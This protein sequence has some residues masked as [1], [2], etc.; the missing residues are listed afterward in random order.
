VDGHFR[1]KSPYPPPLGTQPYS[2][3]RL[4]SGN[5]IVPV[6]S[7]RAE[8]VGSDHN[9]A[10]ERTG[11]T[12]RN[13]PFKITKP[14]VNRLVR[15]ALAPASEGRAN[16]PM[17]LKNSNR[18]PWPVANQLA[19][20]VEKLCV[21]QLRRYLPQARKASI[22]GAR[23]REWLTHIELDDFNTVTACPCR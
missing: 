9:V 10:T 15:F 12:D 1:V 11:F 19:I 5:E 2:Q 16:I 4:F 18:L 3:F 22:A 23:G 20:S 21:S 17:I 6:S 14:V 8:R 7:D 13:I